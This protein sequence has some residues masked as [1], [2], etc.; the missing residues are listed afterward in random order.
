MSDQQ[1]NKLVFFLPNTFTALNMGCGFISMILTFKGSFYLASIFIILGAVFDSVDGRVARLTGTQSSFGEQ[2]DSMSD[3][4]TFGV[5]PALLFYHRF[6]LD[7]GRIGPVVTFIF[8]LCGA[9]RLARFNANIEKV[10]SNYFQGL[11]IPGAAMALAG[12]VLFSVEFPVLAKLTFAAIPY[13]IFYAL[14][15]ISNVPFCSFKDS[16]WVKEHKR[17]VLAIIFISLALVFVYEELIVGIFLSM[18]VVGSIIYFI[19]HRK[20]F[21]GYFSWTDDG[22]EEEK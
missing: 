12:Y 19:S 15:M 21:K 14:L 11:P 7:V 6:L 17:H 1:Q 9:L 4:V 18:Y 13:I 10:S 2:F 5:A 16:K 22:A 8:I 3:L 20:Q